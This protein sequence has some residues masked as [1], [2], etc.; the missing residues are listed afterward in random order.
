MER[1]IIHVDMDAFFASVELLARPEL[2]GRPVIVAGGQERGVVVAATYEARAFGVRAGMPVG[3]ARRRAASA[4]FV[5]PR[6]EAYRRVSRGVMALLGDVTPLVEQVSVDEAFL[7]VTGSLKR[8]GPA[9]D[10]AAGIRRAI[11]A[12]FGLAASAGIGRSKSVAKIASSRAKPDGLLEVPGPLTLAFLRPLPVAALWGIGPAGQA[13]LAR[14]G[15]RTV[16]EL[17]DSPDRL[18]ARALGAAAAAHLLAMARGRDEAPVAPGRA[19]KS[20]SAETTF[21]QD[22]PRGGPQLRRAVMR[23]ADKTAWRLREAG[24]MCRTVGVK[25]RTGDFKTASRSRTLDAPTDSTRAITA[26]AGALVAAIPGT[27]AARLVGV[28]LENLVRRAGAPVQ[29]ALG[30]DHTEAA[31]LDRV[32]DQVRRRFGG[33]ALEPGALIR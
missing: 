22:L 25:L 4:V 17:A 20:I 15:V 6:P 30:E 18:V 24:L 14:I 2:R 12:E 27:G 9:R 26:A 31:A 1:A 21:E 16:A 10:I 11:A 8:L 23:L 19:D 5:E 7:D 28:R 13:A 33:G 29:A 32:R 3:Q